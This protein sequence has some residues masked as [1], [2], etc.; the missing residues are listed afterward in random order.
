[1]F[2]VVEAGGEVYAGRLESDESR[3][4]DMRL[5]C[6]GREE[7]LPPELEGGGENI[8]LVVESAAVLAARCRPGRGSGEKRRR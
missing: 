2:Q 1:V 5:R 8:T 7:R 3:S 6:R 4:A